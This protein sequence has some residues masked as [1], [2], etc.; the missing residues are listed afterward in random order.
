MQLH[1]VGGFLGSGKTTAIIC[2]AK[3]LMAR[4]QK[5]GVITN[6]QG[7]YLVDTAFIRL[8]N[9]PAVE[10][11]GGCF[12]CH[13]DDLEERL[14][15]LQQ[16]IQPDVIFAE[17]VGSC[18][19]LVA[20]VIKPL[21]TLSAVKMKPTSFSVFTDSRLLQMRLDGEEMPFSENVVYIFDKQ[22]EEAPA[23]IINKVDLL[24]PEEANQLLIQARQ[25]F[26]DK[27]VLLQ[28]SL[29]EGSV[30]EWVGLIHNNRALVQND[31]EMDYQRYGMGEA[32]LAWLD[33]FYQFRLPEVEGNL[34]IHHLIRSILSR[35]KQVEAPIGHIK[36]LIRSGSVEGKISFTT[37]AVPDWEHDI[38][39]HLG[40][41][42]DLLI[43]ARAEMPAEALY[44]LVQEVTAQCASEAGA[45]FIE[46]KSDFFHPGFP[47][48]IHRL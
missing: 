6:D 9:I 4:G 5:V 15:Q 20:T 46:K 16:E 28:N 44:Q 41:E 12:C 26:P 10:I 30:Q 21:L 43:N 7:K 1:L 38:P 18:G 8:S 27:I 47:S 45:E 31:L 22:I 39:K 40:S 2:A 14:S 23:L 3:E 32:R 42:I 48:P 37:L 19:D 34:F 36:F 13:Y 17:S 25:N 29:D 35:V 11:T 24:E 33:L